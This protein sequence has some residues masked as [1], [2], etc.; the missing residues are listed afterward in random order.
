MTVV[1]DEARGAWVARSHRAVVDGFRDPRLSSDRVAAFEHLATT[2]PATFRTVVD[3]LAGWMVFR[4]P[5]AHTRLREPVRAAFTPRRVAILEARVEAVVDELLD[6]VEDAGGGELRQALAQPLPAIVIADLLG[7]PAEDRARFQRWSDELAGIVFAASAAEADDHAAIAGATSFTA[8]FRD[9]VEHKRTHPADDLVTAVA[10]GGLDDTDVVGACAMLLFAGHETTTGFLCNALWT[11]FEHPDALDRWRDDPNLDPTAVEELMRV[12]GP[13]TG[14]L[15]RASASFEWEGAAIEAGDAVH[16]S[17]GDANR[18][19]AVF[20]A[21]DE[22]RLD[23]SPNPHV[24]FGWGLHHCLGAPL[25][26]MESRVALR[27]VLDRFP[28][29]TPAAGARAQWTSGVIGRSSG[30]VPVLVR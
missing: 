30:P 12:A 19:P 7:V 6:P 4:D 20:E 3:L 11:L 21:P 15:R 18:D 24:G 23:R 22:L 8:Y 17:I 29:L 27:R 16:L 28:D 25:A 9:L 14:M 5:P 26:R 13:A 1:R 10:A 2:R